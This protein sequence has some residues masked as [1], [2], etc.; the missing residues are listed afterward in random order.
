MFYTYMFLVI[1]FKMP[2]FQTVFIS[3]GFSRHF[4]FRPEQPQTGSATLLQ[5]PGQ[6]E[7]QCLHFKKMSLVKL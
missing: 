6:G 3:S 4:G 2:F 7:R 1:R 5:V